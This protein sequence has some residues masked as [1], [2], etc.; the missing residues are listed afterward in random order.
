MGVDANDPPGAADDR[1]G[2]PHRHLLP[3]LSAD[4]GF[5]VTHGL[6]TP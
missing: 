6:P 4:P 3:Q 1:L 5:S 2:A